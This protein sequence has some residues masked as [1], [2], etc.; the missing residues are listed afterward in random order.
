MRPN[1]KRFRGLPLRDPI[2]ELD[3]KVL[4]AFDVALAVGLLIAAC[5][6]EQARVFAPVLATL[7][8]CFA[9]RQDGKEPFPAAQIGRIPHATPFELD[10]AAVRRAAETLHAWAA[11]PRFREAV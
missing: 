2:H 6:P 9:N 10:A 5:Y 11:A 4:A 3:I 7:G 8:L 1:A